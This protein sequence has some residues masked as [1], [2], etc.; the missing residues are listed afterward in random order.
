[1]TTDKAMTPSEAC[2][3]LQRMFAVF[4]DPNTKQDDL[5]ESLTPDY[6]Q[7]V[8]GKQFDYNEF[9]LRHQALQGTIS[10]GSVNF[11]HFATDGFSGAT[12]HIAEAVK[13]N[14]E[15]IRLRVIAYYQFCGNRIS[16]VDKLTQLLD[17]DQEDRDLGSRTVP[18]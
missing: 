13:R 7:R 4:M 18:A 2:D 12:V 10:S 1:M 8:D 17:G 5:A 3:L 6:V 9:L 16:L 11:E 14:G 15:R